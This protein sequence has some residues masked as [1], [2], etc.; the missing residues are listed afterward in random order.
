MNRQTLFRIM[1]FAPVQDSCAYLV[2]ALDML[3]FPHPYLSRFIMVAQKVRSLLI[4]LLQFLKLHLQL[5]RYS[6]QELIQP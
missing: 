6:K 4:L 1:I 2:I 5:L 3:S